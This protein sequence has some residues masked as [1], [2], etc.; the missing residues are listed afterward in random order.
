[1]FVYPWDIADGGIAETLGDMKA[2]GMDAINVSVSYHTAKLLLPHNPKRKIYYH[3]GGHVYFRPEHGQYKLLQPL[4]GEAYEA[5]RLRHAGPGQDDLLARI[6][7]EAR[8]LELG[9]NAWVVGFHN[10]RL[11]KLH[12]QITVRN[13]YDESYVHAL[14]PAQEECRHYAVQ[15]IRD[16]V[17]QYDLDGIILESFDYMGCLHGDHHEI[18]GIENQGELEK[19]LGLCFCDRCEA[20]AV[21]RGIDV[22]ALKH[23][24]RTRV[25]QLTNLQS[26]DEPVAIAQ[27]ASYLA[28]RSSVVEDVLREI[29]QLMDDSASGISLYSILWLAYGADPAFYGTDPGKLSPYLDGWITCYP[30][31]AA[32]TDDFIFAVKARIPEDK[33]LGGI[34]LIAPQTQRP[35][36]AAACLAAYNQ[37]GVSQV[38]LYNYGLT[39]R[40]TLDAC[41]TYL[42]AGQGRR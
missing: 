22:A 19:L 15:M 4:T 6:I 9:V 24:V 31:T 27:Y 28:M 40:A 37:A 25:A 41:K 5:Y 11:G 7:T 3:P 14:C 1:M 8:K 35:D 2:I 30:E 42:N 39:P 12:P 13:A 16:L 32:E 29:R 10:S 33:L 20:L 38:H 18:I 17:R 36:Q 26:A 23:Q 21:E 34:R